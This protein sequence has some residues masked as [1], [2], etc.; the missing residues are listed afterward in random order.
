MTTL[1]ISATYKKPLVRLWRHVSLRRRKQLLLL[2]FL[3][4]ISS[5]AE[6][7]SIGAILPFLGIITEPNRV[8][9]FLSHQTIFQYLGYSAPE[10]LLLPLTIGF[11]LAAFMAGVMRLL[12]IWASTRLSFATGADISGDIYYRT[13]HQPYSVHTSRNSSELI[14]GITGKVN[15]VIY[16]VIT[17]T[18]TF[19]SNCIILVAILVVLLSIETE[20]SLLALGSLGAIYFIIVLLSRNRLLTNS[21][22]NALESTKAIKALQEGLGGIRDVLIDGSQNYYWKSYCNADLALRR[23]QGENLIISQSPRFIIEAFGMILIASLTYFLA[24]KEGGISSSIPILGVLALGAQRLL[25]VLQQIYGAL[26]AIRSAQGS[27]EDVLVLLDQKVNCNSYGPVIPLSFQKYIKLN[28]V[29]FRYSNE[30]PWLFNKLDITISKGSRVGIIGSTGSGKS[31]IIDIIMGLLPPTEGTLEVDDCVISDE[32]RRSWHAHIAH[33]PQTIFLADISIEENI[34]FGTPRD[35]IDRGLIRQVALQAQIADLIEGWPKQYET[36][37]GERG[38]RL[39][40]G[41]RQRIGIA[42]ALYRKADVIIFDEATSA[43]DHE[44]EEAVMQ[45]IKGLSNKLTL[46]IITHRLS[47]LRGCSKIIEISNLRS[48]NDKNYPSISRVE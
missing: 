21:R 41:Q 27:L 15:L 3:M 47:T 2:L 33:V 23:T 31:T 22:L 37:V 20:I 48:T 14:N 16:S 24:Q 6:V 11:G 30:T 13:L 5:F 46:I 36:L 42:R 10:Q 12:L 28:Q 17:P 1:R 34:A 29:K 44:T 38:V 7:M 43:L 25:P 45:A 9:E 8:Y 26:A 4:I 40:G 35:Q 32:N 39:S 18:L 19:I